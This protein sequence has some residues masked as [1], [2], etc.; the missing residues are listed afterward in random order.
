[1]VRKI[2]KERFELPPSLPK[3]LGHDS[4]VIHVI[5][6]PVYHLYT[7]ETSGLPVYLPTENRKTPSPFVGEY[8]DF[9]DREARK[10]VNEGVLLA[11]I[12]G[13]KSDGASD[14]TCS[15]NC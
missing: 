5:S 6:T 7:R 8:M 14:K 10:M 13:V 15:I 9:E 12:H 11:K 2:P 1:M 3:S 4:C